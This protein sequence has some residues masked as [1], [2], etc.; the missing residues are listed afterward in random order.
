[1][2]IFYFF[3]KNAYGPQESSDFKLRK[4]SDKKA[5]VQF[6]SGLYEFR[7]KRLDIL[8]KKPELA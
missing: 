3:R 1:L 5:G 6:F 2:E 8:R 7:K 4:L